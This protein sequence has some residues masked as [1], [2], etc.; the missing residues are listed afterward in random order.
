[1][2]VQT[3]VPATLLYH[4]IKI[5]PQTPVRFRHIPSRNRTIKAYSPPFLNR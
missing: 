4:R 2:N 3:E 5:R 1:M